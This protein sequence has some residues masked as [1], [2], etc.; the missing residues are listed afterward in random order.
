MMLSDVCRVHL[1][2][3]PLLASVAGL[4]GGISWRTSTYSLSLL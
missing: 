1:V 4:G 3:G 2:G